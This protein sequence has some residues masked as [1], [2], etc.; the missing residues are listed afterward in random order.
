MKIVTRDLSEEVL[1][2]DNEQ[3]DLDWVIYH[4]GTERLQMDGF[5]SVEDLR[6][7]ADWLESDE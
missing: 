4:Q 6:A 7:L 5:F 2:L 1:R 3:G